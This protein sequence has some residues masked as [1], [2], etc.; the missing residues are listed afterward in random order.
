[1]SLQLCNRF[2]D[3]TAFINENR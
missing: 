3:E 2:M 1:M